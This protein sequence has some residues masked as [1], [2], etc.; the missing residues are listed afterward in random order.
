MEYRILNLDPRFYLLLA[1]RL[2]F[3]SASLYLYLRFPHIHNI[4][5]FDLAVLGWIVVAVILLTASSLSI[6]DINIQRIN[7]YL[8]WVLG[9]YFLP[10]RLLYKTI[11]ALLLSILSIY[12]L[13]TYASLS[14]QEF[15]SSIV[16]AKVGS[17]LGMNVIGF[18]I[19]L[20]LDS[21]R[22]HQYL[23][24]KTLIEGQAKL[25]ELATS[26]SL[27]GILNRRSFLEIASTEFDRYQRY[28]EPFSFII[29]DLDKLKT[30]NDTYGHP[31]GDHAIVLLI[32]TIKE[33]K[34]SSDSVGRLAGDEFG[35]ILPGTDAQQARDLL[36]RV[37]DILAET[38]VEVPS[39]QQFQVSFSAGVADVK[40]TDDDFDMLYKRADKALMTAKQAG[41][42]RIEIA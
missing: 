20:R 15:P 9:C 24:Q 33:Q 25:K 11:P 41:R 34:R 35:L 30:I 36:S 22:Y 4:N 16:V 31:A 18:I 23:I 2:L 42:N 17:I 27:T 32:E 3:V 13:V 26:D 28:G 19:S 40:Q 29:L 12:F 21:Q 6:N 38:V 5:T 10:I 7:I 14:L 8:A 1:I 39:K 37:K